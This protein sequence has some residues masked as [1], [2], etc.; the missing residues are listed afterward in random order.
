M[1]D[2]LDIFC[3]NTR[4]LGDKKK[5]KAIFL[6]LQEKGTGIFMLQETH[7]TVKTETD[8]KKQWHGQI[9]FFH[10][11]SNSRGGVRG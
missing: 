8:W 6:W 7:S 3:L 1:G 9:V 5:R 2:S 10:G 4:A 11:L